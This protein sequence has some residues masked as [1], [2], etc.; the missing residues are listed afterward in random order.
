MKRSVLAALTL[1]LIGAVFLAGGA[2]ASINR[3]SNTAVCEAC[4]MEIAKAD[5]S[6]FS[7]VAADGSEHWACCPICAEVVGIYYTNSEING[8]CFVTGKSIKMTVVNGNFSTATVTPAQAGDN[9]TIVLGGSCATNKIVSDSMH[10]A[11][12]RQTIG[13]SNASLTTV[14]QSFTAARTK[15]ASMTVGYKPVSIPMLNYALSGVGAVFLCA[16]PVSWK[17]VQKRSNKA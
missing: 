14:P 8:K 3:T 7:I 6:T 4:G 15:L 17:I 12:A 9:V 11:E 13:V 1:A 10:G 2:S 16:A 5:I